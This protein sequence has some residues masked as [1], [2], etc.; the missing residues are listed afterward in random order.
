M[1]K[2]QINIDW[3]AVFWVSIII[4]F[5]WLLAK[6]V[7]LIHTSWYILIIP[8][9]VSFMAFVS[10]VKRIAEYGFKVDTLI[11]DVKDLKFEIRGTRQDIHSLDKR[12]TVV[13]SK[14]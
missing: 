1:K 4:L 5:L 12:L 6:A 9:I 8:Y 13:E 7:G 3:S 10:G 2:I 14:L 11:I